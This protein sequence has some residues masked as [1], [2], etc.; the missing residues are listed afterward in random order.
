MVR[1]QQDG[2]TEPQPEG[3]FPPEPLEVWAVVAENGRATAYVDTREEA[4]DLA[5]RQLLK[6]TYPLD[7]RGG[8][9]WT[10]NPETVSRRVV[11]LKEAM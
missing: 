5:R 3:E 4:D 1:R 9:L 6:V 8:T 7:G 10:Q 2:E 11:K